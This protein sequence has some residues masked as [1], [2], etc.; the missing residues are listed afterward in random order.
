MVNRALP[1]RLAMTIVAVLYIVAL[2]AAAQYSGGRYLLFPGL[3]A[4]SYEV[5]TRPWGKW[6]RRPGRLIAAPTLA[7][8]LGIAI[9][10]GAPYHA[11]TVLLVVA[12][13]LLLLAVLRSTVAPA[14]A[15]GTLPLVL[16]LK[17]WF[18]PASIALG[19]VVLVGIVL[20]WRNRYLRMD[21][22]C[23]K[24]SG[25]HCADFLDGP[26][27]A[28]IWILPFFL[29]LT[30]L[31]VC[32]AASGL[33]L[34]LFPPLIVL[35]YEMFAHPTSCPW[36]RKP[37]AIPVICFLVSSTGWLAVSLFGSSGLAAAFGMM[38]GIIVLRLLHIHM[39]PAL[40]IGLLPL[41][42]HSPNISYPISA[43]IGSGAL[44]LAFL[45]SRPII[46]QGHAGFR[47]R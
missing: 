4:L 34:I 39:P 19:L 8:A 24:V 30:V 37:F 27:T 11:L 13:C 3:A 20:P 23:P 35:A 25:R 16:G 1:G 40:A 44:A 15:A 32:A 38:S 12:L 36:A 10:R 26:P 41:V 18:Y 33:R 5:L 21:R 42:L 31:A 14:I 7:A 43:A 6:A 9:T 2:A 22:D 28:D 45:F 47:T 29:F 17:S 46:G